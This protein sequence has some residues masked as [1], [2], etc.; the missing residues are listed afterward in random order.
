LTKG[1]I[2]ARL[3]LSE[4]YLL[5]A[6]AFM[7]YYSFYR[8]DCGFFAGKE[9]WHLK[10]CFE[11]K[12]KEI[13]SLEQVDSL[14]PDMSA[15]KINSIYAFCYKNRKKINKRKYGLSVKQKLIATIRDLRK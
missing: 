2:W 11:E 6:R 3:S 12:K 7:D 1:G 4:K 8:S 10:R 9:W 5:N 14:I 15:D 13:K